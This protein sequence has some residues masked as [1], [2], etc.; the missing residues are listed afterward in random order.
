MDLLINDILNTTIGDSLA[1]NLTIMLVITTIFTSKINEL[2]PTSDTKLIDFWLIFSLLVPFTE[3]VLRTA[4]ECLADCEC[5]LCSGKVSKADQEK[6]IFKLDG[7]MVNSID[8]SLV[9]IENSVEN[10]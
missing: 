4:L 9:T 6:G 5:Q 10:I 8:C 1:V 7:R 2:P 3:V